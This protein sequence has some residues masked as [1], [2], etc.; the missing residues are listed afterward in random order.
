M[1]F[2]KSGKPVGKKLNFSNCGRVKED[3]VEKVT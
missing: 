2:S 3:K 1:I